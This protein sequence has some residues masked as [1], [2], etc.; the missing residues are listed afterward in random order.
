MRP[1]QRVDIARAAALLCAGY[2]KAFKW[3]QFVDLETG[4]K[5]QEESVSHRPVSMARDIPDHTT[6]QST[7]SLSPSISSYLDD[8]FTS[9]IGDPHAAFK[10]L[11]LEFTTDALEVEW[12]G[13][14]PANMT[15]LDPD[16]VDYDP[17]FFDMPATFED[18][19]EAESYRASTATSE[20]QITID[21]SKAPPWLG[22]TTFEDF[23]DDA[24]LDAS[25]L[26]LGNSASNRALS[27]FYQQLSSEAGH[28]DLITS[29]FQS[30]TC[31]V[32]S[33]KNDW[34]ENPWRSLIW[35]LTKN[36]PALR[37][38]ISAMTCLQS[39]K[40]RRELHI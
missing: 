32:L 36:N 7:D 26:V 10:A 19:T 13:N 38:A 15:S 30:Q 23:S 5:S 27:P 39:C 24:Q 35:P 2:P 12:P 31:S 4:T 18:G 20:A 9:I 21:H 1:S 25:A 33:V 28:L 22:S 6:G 34:E 16:I 29:L 17:L 11:D 40:L 14:S 37:H 3:K 8:A